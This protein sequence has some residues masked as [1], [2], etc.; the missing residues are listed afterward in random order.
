LASLA[1]HTTG[2]HPRLL[3]INI[4]E[5]KWPEIEGSQ[6]IVILKTDGTIITYDAKGRRFQRTAPVC[7][8]S[9][10]KF[11]ATAMDLTNDIQKSIEAAIKRDVFS[12]GKLQSSPWKLDLVD[13]T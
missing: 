2:S 9:G 11:A 10:W 5:K 6:D 7:M 1:I 4:G 13:L 12:S 8:G 3:Q